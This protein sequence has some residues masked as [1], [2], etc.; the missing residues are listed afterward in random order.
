[1]KHVYTSKSFSKDLKDK[2]LWR[3][4]I[5]LVTAK[6]MYVKIS[7]FQFTF[8]KYDLVADEEKRK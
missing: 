6:L 7:V 2:K 5:F 8:L 4:A 1:M 3:D